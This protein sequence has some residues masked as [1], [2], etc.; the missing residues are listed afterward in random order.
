M[1]WNKI[2]TQIFILLFIILFLY[3]CISFTFGYRENYENA[4]IKSKEREIESYLKQ[5]NQ[6]NFSETDAASIKNSVAVIEPR[7]V[8]EKTKILRLII[9]EIFF[10]F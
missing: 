1:N 10:M 5:L 2:I 7:L 9:N 4:D 8:Q 3:G 6:E